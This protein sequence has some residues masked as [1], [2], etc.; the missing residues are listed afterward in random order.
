MILIA[1]YLPFSALCFLPLI[2]LCRILVMKRPGIQAMKFTGTDKRGFLILL[3]GNRSRFDRSVI[4]GV[5]SSYSTFIPCL[6]R[7]SAPPLSIRK[8]FSVPSPLRELELRFALRACWCGHGASPPSGAVFAL[9][10]IRNIRTSLSR[11]ASLP[12]A[13]I[14]SMLAPR[15]S[16][17][18]NFWCSRTGFC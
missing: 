12:S 10:S 17:A 3:F 5:H 14:R 2:V 7:P 6:Q 4:R 8:R 16:C 9:A 1:R 11:R 18:A 15:L 13:A